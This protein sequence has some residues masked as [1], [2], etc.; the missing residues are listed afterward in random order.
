MKKNLITVIIL[1]LVLANLILT[2]ILVFTIIPQTKKSNQ[3]IDQVCS[4][5][6][7]ELQSGENT[8]ATP[9]VPIEDVETYA[10]T[11]GF[12]VN[13]K[14]GED[15]KQH[16]AVFSV[17]LSLNTKSDGYKTYGG[18][19]GLAAKVTIIQSEI[20]TIVNGY[21]LDEF[22][23]NGYQSVKDDILKTLQDMFGGS[24]FIVGVNFSSVQTE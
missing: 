8:P 13:L 21:T 19:E 5:I 23:A 1:A 16:Y 15:G 17:S 6:N 18:S 9:E 7:L 10:I 3:L 4:A 20:N 24:D 11:D 14:Q 12:T 22:N 2:A